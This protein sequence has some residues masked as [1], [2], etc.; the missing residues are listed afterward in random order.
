MLVSGVHLFTRLQRGSTSVHLYGEIHGNPHS[1]DANGVDVV[2]LL[3]EQVVANKIQLYL[4]QPVDF[5]SDSTNLYCGKANPRQVLNELRTCMYIL[6]TQGSGRNVHFIDP[7]ELFGP[8][9]FTAEEAAFVRRRPWNKR[10]VEQRFLL[11]L[12]AATRAL[13][14][15]VDQKLWAQ[16]ESCIKRMK[17]S[18]AD[19]DIR[20]VQ[21]L[22]HTATDAVME[23]YTLSVLLRNLRRQQNNNSTH[24]VY[25]GATHTRNLH[26]LLCETA[27]FETMYTTTA[28]RRDGAS[29]V[30]VG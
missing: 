15:T 7:R 29:C 20:A 28:R 1:C 10:A 5:N 21:Q 4:E 14:H 11:P 2:S 26:K 30:V 6:K 24:V 9:P 13:R 8:L 16:V 22:Y 17:Q 12:Q 18:I 27:G 23:L 3:R 25:T 19:E